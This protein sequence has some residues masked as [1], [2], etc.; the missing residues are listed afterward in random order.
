MQTT[1][2]STGV[3]C[4]TVVRNG[5]D[6]DGW[7]RLGLDPA[8]CAV[9][10]RKDTP[11]V[12]DEWGSYVPGPGKLSRTRLLSVNGVAKSRRSQP[13][14][15]LPRLPNWYAFTSLRALVMDWEGSAGLWAPG[16]DG[17]RHGATQ[18]TRQ[19]TPA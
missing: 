1:K 11:S 14:S 17:K 6:T 18:N 12:A 10:S 13:A 16:P 3:L 2:H 4:R 19:T 5:A 8:A 9:R 7:R 15:F